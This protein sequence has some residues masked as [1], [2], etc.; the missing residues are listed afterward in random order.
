MYQ[1]TRRQP[2]GYELIID[3]SVP[4]G[5]AEADTLSCGHCNAIVRL[6]GEGGCYQCSSPLCAAC[7]ETG[8]CLPFAAW[9]DAHEGT[10]LRGR[11]AESFTA[12]NAKRLGR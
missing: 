1:A 2:G 3:P 6:G 12:W 5:Y 7:V 4:G 11:W 8:V 9:L 10:P